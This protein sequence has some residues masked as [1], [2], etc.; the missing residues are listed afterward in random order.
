M[1]Q[2]TI[3]ITTQTL[4][5]NGFTVWNTPPGRPIDRLEQV[6]RAAENYSM[7]AV[8][9]SR[10]EGHGPAKCE[11]ARLLQYYLAG[12]KRAWKTTPEK[13]HA[14]KP[15][16]ILH[17]SIRDIEIALSATGVELP[18]FPEGKE[19]QIPNGS[20]TELLIKSRYESLEEPP[21]TLGELNV[22]T[23]VEYIMV[24]KEAAF[25]AKADCNHLVVRRI[26]VYAS[27]KLILLT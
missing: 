21:V 11:C 23:L 25:A 16:Q 17:R 14:W 18:P 8:D 1:H 27:I 2:D 26:L 5:L 15:A 9:L 6:C 20:V 19:F 13:W 3:K 7:A 4:T 12:F 22:S 10:F 24:K